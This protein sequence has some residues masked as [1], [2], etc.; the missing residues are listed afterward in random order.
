[1][2]IHLWGILIHQV[3]RRAIRRPHHLLVVHMVQ[4]VAKSRLIGCHI[5]EDVDI[6]R[7]QLEPNIAQCAFPQRVVTMVFDLGKTTVG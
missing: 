1:M 7:E 4:K 5:C 3:L 6:G 2:L